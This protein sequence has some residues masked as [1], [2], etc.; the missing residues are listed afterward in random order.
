MPE[1]FFENL[2]KKINEK[3]SERKV[4]RRSVSSHWVEW[5]IAVAVISVVCFSRIHI[6]ND[7]PDF[8]TGNGLKL[9]NLFYCDQH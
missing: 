8:A 4:S 3:I 5:I 1:F 7:K 6:V 9:E 2:E